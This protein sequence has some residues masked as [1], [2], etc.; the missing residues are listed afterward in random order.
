MRASRERFGH[1]VIVGWAD[2]LG[3]N[4]R[5]R[6]IAAQNA[7]YK[8]HDIKGNRLVITNL[9]GTNDF[10]PDFRG[11]ATLV[12]LKRNA[13]SVDEGKDEVVF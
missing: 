4:R 7:Y 2:D 1:F 8:Q 10:S 12:L 3:I 13:A 6:P 11:R 5:P 9:Y